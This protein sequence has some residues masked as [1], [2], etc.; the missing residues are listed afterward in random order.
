[1][2]IRNGTTLESTGSLAA[3]QRRQPMDH[4]GK[5]RENC[6]MEQL[7]T[8]KRENN[9]CLLPLQ[10]INVHTLS[11]LCQCY[12]WQ[13]EI[14]AGHHLPDEWRN[15]WRYPYKTTDGCR[16]KLVNNVIIA[17]CICFCWWGFPPSKFSHCL[18]SSRNSIACIK[19]DV[20]INI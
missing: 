8:I 20:K 17:S 2:T 1:M 7:I 9:K 15:I 19:L 18:E 6:R 11:A 13:Q 14:F 5:S 4:A 12:L 16:R 3:F 10:E